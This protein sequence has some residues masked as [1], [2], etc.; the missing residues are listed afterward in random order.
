MYDVSFEFTNPWHTTVA[1]GYD[2][3]SEIAENEINDSRDFLVDG[4]GNNSYMRIYDNEFYDSQV[5]L[6]NFDQ[7]SNGRLIFHSNYSE[8]STSDFV[9]E[10]D[11][12]DGM[13]FANNH[14]ENLMYYLPYS[15]TEYLY[16]GVRWDDSRDVEVSNNYLENFS[17]GFHVQGN[18]TTNIGGI[19]T[20]FTC[21]EFVN[22]YYGFYFNSAAIS[23]QG[24]GTKATDNC[25]NYYTAG[26]YPYGSQTAGTVSSGSKFWYIRNPSSCSGTPPFTS[27][28]CI[29][30]QA[31]GLSISSTA[32][33][34]NSC[35]IPS[36]KSSQVRSESKKENA[37]V[38]DV[39]PNPT[40]NKVSI[41][42][43]KSHEGAVISIYNLMGKMVFEGELQQGSIDID[44]TEFKT[45]LYLIKVSGETQRLIIQ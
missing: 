31:I 15:G 9:V 23:N 44:L 6:H 17:R 21:N 11:Q 19:G 12:C 22:C 26:G 3:G 27:C 4:N 16:V 5:L 30:N 42:N 36:N 1:T 38:F 24:S 20:Q 34:V 13:T 28:Y 10:V 14:L 45:G 7:Q 8:M 2:A 33:S 40:T 39:Y 25:F 29:Q 32:A 41:I 37:G 18:N 43:T 35:D